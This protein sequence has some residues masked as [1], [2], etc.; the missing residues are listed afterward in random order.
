MDKK[1]QMIAHQFLEVNQ[2]YDTIKELGETAIKIL[3][4]CVNQESQQKSLDIIRYEI[5]KTK[6]VDA[7]KFVDSKS[8]PPTTSALKYHSYRCYYQI[9]DWMSLICQLDPLKWAW[10][11][12]RG[13][14]IPICTDQPAAPNYLLASLR[15]RCKT[16]CISPDCTCRK[17]GLRCT[18]ACGP[19]QTTNCFNVQNPDENEEEGNATLKL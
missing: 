18:Y 2:N 10:K 17:N 9:Q 11:E 7:K 6:F 12:V 14:L 5:F 3:Y 16:E 13:K 19:C 1:L 8:L 15:C 4:N